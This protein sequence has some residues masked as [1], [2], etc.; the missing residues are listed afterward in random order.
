MNKMEDKVSSNVKWKREEV[1]EEE[2]E[3]IILYCFV[4]GLIEIE[5]N[6]I[7]YFIMDKRYIMV[8]FIFY[9]LGWTAMDPWP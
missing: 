7:S 2:E 8:F 6:F 3:D 1:E 5:P 4:I 9:F